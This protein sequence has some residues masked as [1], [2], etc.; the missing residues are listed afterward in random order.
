M[1]ILCALAAED[2]YTIPS[3]EG[4]T[5]I[6]AKNC[7]GPNQTDSSSTEVLHLLNNI[8]LEQQQQQQKA[9]NDA[10]EFSVFP[11]T[12][13]QLRCSNHRTDTVD[14][15]ESIRLSET[16]CRQSDCHQS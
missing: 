3:V 6:T 4:K 5:K 10:V 1:S 9:V 11:D 2:G 12:R 15:G 16:L 8:Q 14:V 13:F 7:L